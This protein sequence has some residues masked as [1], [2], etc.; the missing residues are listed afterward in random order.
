MQNHI[1]LNFDVNVMNI[2]NVSQSPPRRR[3][4]LSPSLEASVEQKRIKNSPCSFCNLS[5]NVTNFEEHIQNS[6]YC[7]NLYMK[8]HRVS[9]VDGILI[10]TFDCIFCPAKIYRLTDHLSNAADC[11]AR[12]FQRFHVDVLK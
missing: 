6:D 2:G 5:K 3:R 12:Y 8:L 10:K 7:R 1:C 11:R 9:T 4:R